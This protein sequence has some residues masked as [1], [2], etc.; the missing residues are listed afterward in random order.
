MEINRNFSDK[1]VRDYYLIKKAKK[2]DEHAFAELLGYYRDALFRLLLKMVK[3][4]EDAEDLMIET[5]EKAFRKIGSYK[6]DYAFSTWLFRIATNH[7]IDYIRTA[8][9][10][11]DNVYIDKVFDY[12][13][14]FQKSYIIKEES[15]NPEE[16]IVSTQEKKII[17]DVVQ[18][19]PPDYRRI[20]ILRYFE[21]YSYNE[22]AEKL[23][24]PIGT[25]KA[26][27]FR[28]RELLQSILAKHNIKYGKS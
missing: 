10:K 24:L 21:D 6:S 16:S 2:G 27:L 3:S 25:V 8:Q 7:G 18:K 1:A 23:N 22:I 12:D 19:L 11:Y 14:D 5:F 26:R 28:S 15:L 4:K 20:V 13:N 9:N 17:K